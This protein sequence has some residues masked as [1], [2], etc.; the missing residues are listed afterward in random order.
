MNNKKIFHLVTVSKSIP[1]MKGQIE[2]LR[3]RGLDVHIVSSKGEEQKIY[4]SNIV[5]VIN[6]EREI[7]IKNDIKSLYNM[8]KLFIKEKPQIVNSGTPKA[9]LIGT[10]AA[11]ITRRPV[12]IYTVRGLRLETVTGLKYKIL[13]AM[14]KLAMFCATDVIA[15]SESLKKRIV[16]LGLEKKENLSVL[17][18]GSSN[19]INLDDYNK[20]DDYIPVTIANQLENHFVIGYV[21]R[22]VKDKGI[23]EVVEVFKILKLKGYLVKL[24]VVGEIEEDDSIDKKYFNFLES[25]D[26]VILTGQVNK[27]VCYYNH[28]DVLLF[29]TYREGFGNVS[30]EAQAV[31]VPVITSN[32]TGAQDTV[33][34]AQ[35]GFIV[36]IGDY[37]AMANKTEILMNNE[38]LRQ[39]LGTNAR[40]RVA[41]RFKSEIVWKHLETIYRNKNF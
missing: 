19:G 25:N 8:I 26:D 16:Y 15:I 29:P 12:R 23:R 7:S 20:N 36:D 30:I 14:E 32:A 34:D 39:R 40:A 10:L 22:I 2:Y 17:G 35:T 11:F 27:P 28:M 18:Y 1:L 24:L 38:I 37:K 21:G 5:H 13:Y 41:K 6:M 31:E 33:D 4:S 9:G 3:D